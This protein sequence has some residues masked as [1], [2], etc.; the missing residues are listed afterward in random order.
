M[1]LAPASAEP[2]A[3]DKPG[4]KGSHAWRQPARAIMAIAGLWSALQSASI[5]PEIISV[6]TAVN[7]P[8]M[9]PVQAAAIPPLLT[10][11]DVA[12]DAETGSGKT[13]SYRIPITQMLLHK[14]STRACTPS[15]SVKSLVVVPTRELADQVHAAAAALFAA[16]P[17]CV[18]PVSYIDGDSTKHGTGLVPRHAADARIV[19]ATPDRLG[20]VVAANALAC[21][22]L[23]LL[24]LDEANRLLD[25]SFAVTLTAILARLPKERRTGFHS[26]TQT[27][28]V[29]ELA[30]AGLRNPVR[31][32]VRV[33]ALAPAAAPSKAD[34]DYDLDESEPSSGSKKDAGAM[35]ED[36]ASGP[37][38]KATP[39]PAPPALAD[40]FAI[41]TSLT[42][43]YA[44]VRHEHKVRHFVRLLAANPGR[45][46]A[47]TYSRPRASIFFARLPLDAMVRNV[48]EAERARNES[49]K[50]CD[51]TSIDRAVVALHGSMTQIKRT[52]ALTAFATTSN[53]LLCVHRCSSARSRYSRCRLRCPV[54]ST[55]GPGCVRESC[56]LYSTP[57][58]GG[59][60][61][62]LSCAALERLL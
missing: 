31:V 39:K 43:S 16:L 42:C 33:K 27:E 37:A 50:D 62:N 44:I 40:R 8:A 11:R 57:R 60:V 5:H 7:Y 12:V 54:R 15:P 55:A 21:R 23:D 52:R 29:D 30:H 10:S 19:V 48:V 2:A 20:V 38:K 24:I 36:D 18:V 22:D 1:T 26:A 58:P 3:R 51:D 59:S 14:P 4:D 53:A 47:F 13:L 35:D 17:G 61:T 45:S 25:I 6:L 46:L 49:I 9:V 56:G 28:Q 32:A 41:P 34:K